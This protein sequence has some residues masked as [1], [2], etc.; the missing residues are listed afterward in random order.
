MAFIAHLR[1][2]PNDL[3]DLECLLESVE[4]TLDVDVVLDEET[5]LLQQAERRVSSWCPWPSPK[6]EVYIEGASTRGVTLNLESRT[7]GVDISITIPVLAT[8]TDWELGVQLVCALLGDNEHERSARVEGIGE[9]AAEG[10]R[11]TFLQLEERYLSELEEGWAAMNSAIDEGRRV[12][13]G[14]PAGYASIGKQCWQRLRQGTEPGEEA[15]EPA[16]RLVQMIQA[17]IDRRGFDD[18]EEANPLILD[19]PGGRRAVAT[20]L[21]PG[22]NLIL[23]DPEFVLVSSNLEDA[24]DAELLLLPF[25]RF[26]EAFPALATW[27]DERC[28]AVPALPSASWPATIERLRPLLVS[29]S[30]LL[31]VPSAEFDEITDRI[32]FPSMRTS[33]PDG[34]ASRRKWWKLW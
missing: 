15:D 23:R 13:I 24:E 7:S 27:L 22:R 6:L 2:P 33:T 30:D 9:F 18:F 28:C 3:P 31:D 26:E 20:L 1:L 10:M 34:G 21:S 4:D 8:W 19:G 17:S 14:G 11:Q 25:E 5:L 29:V 32:P 16:L 12:R